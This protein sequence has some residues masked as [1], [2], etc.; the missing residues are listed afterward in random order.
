MT[1]PEPPRPRVIDAHVH[2]WD[3]AHRARPWITDDLAALRRGFDPDDLRA[4]QERTPVA[5]SVLVQTVHELDETSDYLALAADPANG[6]VG[7]V[8]WVDLTG[9][10][11]A[12][13]TRLADVPGAERLVGV[14]HI[15]HD[16]DD[17]GWI[18]RDE[19]RRGLAALADADL[20]FDLVIRP[21]QLPAAAAVVAELPQLTFV[22][23]HIAKPVIGGD[24]AAWRAWAE[25]MAAIAARPGTG[26]KISGLVTEAD[27]D[28]WTTEDF[29]PYVDHVRAAFGPDRTLFG[30][31]WPVCTLAAT[32]DRVVD[33]AADLTD[34]LTAAQRAGFWGGNAA[35]LYGLR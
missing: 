26:C 21:A 19:V 8:G 28:A 12:Q 32:Y 13:L 18:A 5:G 1:P 34:D 35:R 9:D 6:I 27:G 33:L 14:R 17:P 2:L 25:P 4:A 15:V 30:S 31:D 22:V 7:V 16:E 20:V 24:D 23:D 10:V 3:L 29:R 11:P